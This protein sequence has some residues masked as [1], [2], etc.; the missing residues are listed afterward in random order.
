MKMNKNVLITMAWLGSGCAPGLEAAPE[1][2]ASI[3]EPQPGEETPEDENEDEDAAPPDD[4]PPDAPPEEGFLPVAGA[5]IT[6]DEGMLVDECAM[7]SWVLDG[8]GKTLMLDVIDAEE[9]EIQGQ[10]EPLECSYDSNGFDCAPSAT[11]DTTAQDEYSLDALIVLSL[12]TS[13]DFDG[14]D[15][16]EM[17]TNITA[18]C[19]GSD[20]WLVELATANFPC[21]MAVW[22]NVEAT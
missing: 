7:E 2:G 12:Q 4:G 9:L 17:W 20:C 21:E 5:W 11:E 15:F 13:G 6:T 22:T 8:A 18:N 3:G 10:Y 1:E 14:P 16:F 19:T